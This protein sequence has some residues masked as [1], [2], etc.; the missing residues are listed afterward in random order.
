MMAYI[1]NMW[2]TIGAVLL[3]TACGPA[4][5]EDSTSTVVEPSTPPTT[6]TRATQPTTATAT[7]TTTPTTTTAT[8]TPT[9][10]RSPTGKPANVG[11]RTFGG[12]DRLLGYY[13]QHALEQVGPYGLDPTPG[14]QDKNI[15]M[16]SGPV[17]FRASADFATA[18]AAATSTPAA[19]VSDPGRS[20]SGTNVQVRG[21]DEAD[22]VKTDGNH[23]YSIV[24]PDGRLRIVETGNFPRLLSTL[25]PGFAPRDMLLWE[26]SLLLIGSEWRVGAATRV[27]EVDISDR[28]IPRIVAELTIDGVYSS[29][30]MVNGIARMVI[31][32]NP[33]GIDWETPRGSGILAEQEATEA[34]RRLIEQSTLGNWL[35]AYRLETDDGAV[36][37]QLLDC[38]RVLAPAV[39]SGLNTLAIVVFD[40]NTT[41]LAA[42]AAAG[43]AAEGETVY[44]TGDSVYV[45]TGQWTNRQTLT[46]SK[47]RPAMSEYTTMIHKFDTSHSEHP[48][49]EASGEI[50]GYL[51][52][53]FAMDEHDGHLRVAATTS[54]SW[55]WDENSESH[56][57]VLRR[58]GDLLEEVGSVWGLGRGERI[59]A[60]RFM[61][62]DGYVV[63]FRQID[64][65]YALD[66]ADP[67]RPRVLGE[68]KIP[69]FSS[70]LH[71]VGDGLLLGI[72]QD[73]SP[74]GRTTGL[75]LSLFDVS[76]PT[77]P[78]RIAHAR[79]F[80]EW[81][82]S[83]S[84]AEHD[85][86]AFLF[87]RQHVFVPYGA[88]RSAPVREPDLDDGIGWKHPEPFY[89]QGVL[90]VNVENDRLTV[91]GRLRPFPEEWTWADMLGWDTSYDP[92]R[93]I[94]VG[95]R[96]YS[97][98][99]AGVAAHRMG[100]WQWVTF[101][102]YDDVGVPPLS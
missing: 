25:D 70:Y 62:P 57:T 44:A 95:D 91:A 9:V 40:L 13:Q 84:P 51:L 17:F 45:A 77:S 34:N 41:G 21:V 54:P 83:R 31:T 56:V 85:H 36:W 76:D 16:D 88:W 43:V 24:D 68:L 52:N 99:Q 8:T 48:V 63:T 3:V 26:D 89:D 96:V 92:R 30:R 37:G 78:Q 79:P 93:V 47:M 1:R 53:Q 66:L 98:S 61:G 58:N 5:T 101:L 39:F 11:L 35:P 69:G 65:L 55:W 33:V 72:G 100:D 46:D 15:V 97:I 81:Q 74:Q 29:A 64:P 73:A 50:E 10:G 7:T 23:I 27:I 12:C 2:L 67:T 22:L 59:F 90:V 80:Q 49:Y 60:V 4:P 75:Q 87:H 94:T 82:S 28:N 38:D 6:S 32:S 20:F 71:P 18:A 19:A 86:R 102:K 42:W 14:W